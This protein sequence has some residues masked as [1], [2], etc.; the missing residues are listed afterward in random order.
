M[1]SCSTGVMLSQNS[2]AWL[3]WSSKDAGFSRTFGAAGTASGTST[4]AALG[5]PAWKGQPP[6]RELGRYGATPSWTACLVHAVAQ[7]VVDGRV[8]AVDRELVEVRAAQPG[9]LG[10]EVGEEPRLEQR[11]VGD[12]DAGHEV[13][14]VEGDLLGLGEEVRRRGGQGEQPD[15]LHRSELLRARSSS[16]RAGRC[17]RRS[18]PACRGRPGCPAP[19]AGTRRPRWRRRG[20]VGGSRGRRRRAAA[21]PPRPASARPAAASSGTS[22]ALVVPSPS[23]QPEGVDPEALHRAGRSAGCARSDMSQMVWCC[24]S[25]CSETKSQNVSWARL[26]LRDLPVGVRLAGVDDVG[27]LDPVLDEEDRHVVADEVEGALVGVELRREAAGVAH[28]VGRAARARAPSRTARTPVSRRPPRG[29]R[30]TVRS[31]ALP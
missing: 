10:V 3:K 2:R 6:S 19:T 30:P 5:V 8:G 14:H 29:R 11:V 9:E 21:P 23:T 31:E 18:G 24:A 7:H 4:N 17:P 22:P 16:G 20:R 13:A 15:G 28:R 1:C 12:V 27:E 26:R 25:V